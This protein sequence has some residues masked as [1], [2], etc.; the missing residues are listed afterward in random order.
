MNCNPSGL[1]GSITSKPLTK[2]CSLIVKVKRWVALLLNCGEHSAHV[3][4][5]CSSY[6]YIPLCME[7]FLSTVLYLVLGTVNKEEV[8]N[9]IHEATLDEPQPS[10]HCYLPCVSF[11]AQAYAY[12]LRSK[13]YR[14]QRDLLPGKCE[15]D[16]NLRLRALWVV[17]GA[18]H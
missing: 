8:K 3:Q 13:P 5:I 2:P 9:T 15:E 7:N 6:L 4:R 10:F 14:V 16:C 11:A 18:C 17:F 1:C 12:L